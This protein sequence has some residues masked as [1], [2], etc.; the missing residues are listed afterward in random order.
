M[1]GKK[2]ETLPKK[3][4]ETAPAEESE[5]PEDEDWSDGSSQSDAEE[6]YVLYKILNVPRDA[7]EEQIVG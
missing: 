2:K 6:K 5:G 3:P 4:V 7:T 1:K